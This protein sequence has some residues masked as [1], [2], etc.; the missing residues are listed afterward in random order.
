MFPNSSATSATEPSAE[1]R[2]LPM[3]VGETLR[4]PEVRRVG[5]FSAAYL[6]VST[7]AALAS[8]N[9]EF[10]FYLV[11]MFL[12]AAGV[13]EAH[14]R[15][16]LT[17]GLLWCLTLWGLMHMAG[18]LLPVPQSW[19]INGEIRVLYS[20]WLISG[21][22]KYDHIT[23]AFGFAVTTWLC[24]QGLRRMLTDRTGVPA[25]QIM[26]TLGMVVLCAAAGMGFG[27]LNEVVEFA[28][29]LM[30]PGTNVGGYINTG[31]DL[32]SNLAGC[33][34]AAVAIGAGGR[35]EEQQSQ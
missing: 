22:L 1:F 5:L 12:L 26:P 6:L 25:Q 32:V 19:P 4:R 33:V 34:I 30:M 31:W 15:I 20:L 21:W 2:S 27:A 23:H 3:S 17:E 29:T 10:V 7:F 18:G 35:R 28:A 16:L 14:R 8:G 9:S 11:V 13:I 24:W